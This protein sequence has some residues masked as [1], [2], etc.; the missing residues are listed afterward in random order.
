MLECDVV[1]A[2]LEETPEL[3]SFGNHKLGGISQIMRRVL[4]IELG[5]KKIEE[6]RTTD[7]GFT[8]R[9]L[10]PTADDIILGIRF[11]I[12]AVDLLIGDKRSGVMVGI[13]GLEI[14]DCGYAEALKM[15]TVHRSD[16]ELEALGVFIS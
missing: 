12:K 5:L 10:A 3:D 9:G 16:K 8:L 2:L 4:K 1:R 14:S 13:N 11:G 6:I 15:K 7:L